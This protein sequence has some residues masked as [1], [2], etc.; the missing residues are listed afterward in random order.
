MEPQPVWPKHP[1]EPPP[2]LWWRLLDRVVESSNTY[3]TLAAQDGRWQPFAPGVQIK[4]LYQRQG[5]LS[6]LLQLDAGASIY[7]HRHALEEECI[8]LDGD[9]QLGS[10]T[11]FGAGSYHV[12]RAGTWHPTLRSRS[13]A[14]LFL[15]GAVPPVG[16][17]LR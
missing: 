2:S 4:F 17:G 16:Y 3:L 9:V 6:Y 15:R 1:P 7:A 11:E 10:Q 8:V 5:V 12:A 13:G 14:L